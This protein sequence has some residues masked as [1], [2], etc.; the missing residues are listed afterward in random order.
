VLQ[1]ELRSALAPRFAGRIGYLHDQITVDR[2]GRTLA[3]GEGTRKES[4]AYLGLDARF[5]RV[6]VAGIE[7]I[8]LDTEPYD[9]WFHHDKAFL[10][11]QTT[12]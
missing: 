3:G 8:E 10:A 11:L 12:F 9:V 4:R 1:L 7:G 2:T 6:R 5:G